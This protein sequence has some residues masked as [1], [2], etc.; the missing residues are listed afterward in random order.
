MDITE[1]QKNKIDAVAKK[2]GL[3]FVILHGSYA[4]GKIRSAAGEVKGSDLDIAVLGNERLSFNVM[5]DLIGAFG[6]IFGDGSERELDVKQLHGVDSLFRFFVVKDGVLLYGDRTAY[7]E[8]CAFAYRDY[9]DSRDLRDLQNILLRK[10]TRSI[11]E[12]FA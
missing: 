7:D 8:F 3:R 10:S 11:K 1:K 5:L 4:T 6:D 2:H 9:M 12:Q